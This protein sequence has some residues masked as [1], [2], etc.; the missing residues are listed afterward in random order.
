MKHHFKKLL[1]Q[2]ALVFMVPLITYG[3]WWDWR[4]PSE[5]S[6]VERRF[7]EAEDSTISGVA[8][9]IHLGGGLYMISAGHEA[10][11]YDACVEV[12]RRDRYSRV[13]V[14]GPTRIEPQ[15]V[16]ERRSVK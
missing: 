5:C 8:V 13:V 1:A 12:L 2:T 7:V 11:E 10:Y 14:L 15:Q 4:Y 9:G 3:C 6:R 16:G